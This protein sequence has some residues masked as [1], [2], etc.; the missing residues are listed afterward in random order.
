MMTTSETW[1]AN[2]RT[3]TTGQQEILLESV[4]DLLRHPDAISDVLETEA[5]ILAEEVR[6][7]LPPR[8]DGA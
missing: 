3:L 1:T 4:S 7:N 6:R 5:H 2:L 8:G